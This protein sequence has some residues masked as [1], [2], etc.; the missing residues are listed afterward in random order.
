MDTVDK[1]NIL[2]TDSQ[3]DLACACGT[4]KGDDHRKRGEDGHWLYPVPLARGGYGIMLKTLLSNACSSDCRYCPLRSE[5]NVR[6]CSLSPE[7]TAKVFM[8][9]LRRKKLIGLFLSSGVIGTPDITMSK[10]NA[11]AEILRKKYQYRGYIHLK[12]IPGASAA[13]IEHSLSLAS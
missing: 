2:S 5:S 8:D 3:Y 12:I 4:R 1:L 13:A 9:F 7:E 6:R 10:L 11:V